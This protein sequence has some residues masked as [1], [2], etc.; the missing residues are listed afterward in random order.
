MKAS[1]SGRTGQ[2]H[3]AFL[4]GLPYVRLRREV[5]EPL[6]ALAAPVLTGERY[7][8]RPVYFSD[9]IV[10]SDTGADSLDDLRGSTWAYNE[11]DSQVLAVELRDHPELRDSVR[12]VES[13]GPS[14]IQPLVATRV[15]SATLRQEVTEIVTALGADEAGRAGLSHGLVERFVAVDDDC[16]S[17]IRAMLAAVEAIPSPLRGG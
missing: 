9:V 7:A 5:S 11:P 10:A 15:A 8:R 2:V 1:S 16:Y 12:I 13:I 3:F 6:E 17:D 4:C 14:T